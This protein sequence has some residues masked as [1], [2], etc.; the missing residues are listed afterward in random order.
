MTEGHQPHRIGLRMAA[1][2]KVLYYDIDADGRVYWLKPALNG[3]M[4]RYRVRD[5]L[6]VERII[7]MASKSKP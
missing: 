5:P 1:D 7:T 3:K 4:Q 6:L 2:D